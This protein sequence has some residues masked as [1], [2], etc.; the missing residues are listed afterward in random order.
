M[1]EKYRKVN[2]LSKGFK[3][4]WELETVSVSIYLEG[5]SASVGYQGQKS[6]PRIDWGRD[7]V[8]ELRKKFERICSIPRC[9][10]PQMAII[11]ALTI[12]CF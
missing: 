5:S 8:F 2:S 11:L 3:R 12:A 9:R 4:Y 7:D 10:D 6:S 1:I